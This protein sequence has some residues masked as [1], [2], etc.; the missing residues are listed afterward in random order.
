M[1]TFADLLVA[2]KS[3]PTMLLLVLLA[4]SHV[5]RAAAEAIVLEA[6]VLNTCHSRTGEHVRRDRFQ[7]ALSLLESSC[8]CTILQISLKL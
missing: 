8:N 1:I 6:V 7:S 5:L 2:R 3:I 4:T